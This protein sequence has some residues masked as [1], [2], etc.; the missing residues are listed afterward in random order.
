MYVTV[1][2]KPKYNISL[3][4]NKIRQFSSER[5]PNETSFGK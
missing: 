5:R 4:Q 3:D 2:T 1:Q